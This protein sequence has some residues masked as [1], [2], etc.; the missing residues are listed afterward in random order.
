[1][2]GSDSESGEDTLQL[3]DYTLV[4]FI[5]KV[6]RPKIEDIDV[7]PTKWLHFHKGRGRYRVKFFGTPCEI[8]DHDCLNTLVKTLADPP[9]SYP[10]S[11]V[12]SGA[13]RTNK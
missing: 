13:K 4:E 11:G 3:Y 10:D 6:R 12:H 8:E 5:H 1:M 2:S 7:V 9:D